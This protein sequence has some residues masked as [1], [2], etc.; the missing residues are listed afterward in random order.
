[1]QL[2]RSC[3]LS[4]QAPQHSAPQRCGPHPP[5]PALE[6]PP[7]IPP[8][9]LPP[10][11]QVAAACGK[12][13]EACEALYR[14]QHAYLS[15]PAALQSAQAFAAMVEAAQKE[16]PVKEEPPASQQR[17][18]SAAPGEDGAA[19]GAA[20]PRPH[21]SS[22]DEG[23]GG[24]EGHREEEEEPGLAAGRARRTPKRG[25]LLPLPGRVRPLR[26]GEAARQHAHQCLQHR[27]R[28]RLLHACQRSGCSSVSR[29]PTC[30]QRVALPPW[31]PLDC[32]AR[33]AAHACVRRQARAGRR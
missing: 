32:A 4:P 2:M 16:E 9:P 26:A 11:P 25:G 14:R 21:D 29:C 15:I 30:F 8:P 13:A 28:R 7:P 5:S 17:S 31:L 18:R 27:Q 20:G 6:P 1:M 10:A 12:P 24:G 23:G 33:W 19:S 22:G 3:F